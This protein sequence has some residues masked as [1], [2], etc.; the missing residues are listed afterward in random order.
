MN[1][2]RKMW[3]LEGL[4]RKEEHTSKGE[5]QRL[6]DLSLTDGKMHQRQKNKKARTNQWMLEVFSGFEIIPCIKS[7]NRRILFTK[8][9]ERGEVNTS[10]KGIANVFGEFHSKLYDD[11]Q[12]DNTETEYDKNETENNIEDRG[13]D[14]KEM[15]E[16]LEITTEELQTQ[17]GKI[18]RQQWNQSRRHQSVRRRNERD[19]ETDLQWNNKTQRIYTRSMAKNQNKSKTQN[20]WRWR[21]WKLSPD[22]LFACAVQTVYDNT[23]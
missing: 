5:K 2:Q 6:K 18:S 10:R 3:R 12:Y 7:A 4:S 20:R 17:K 15:K 8:K 11:D 13:T 19:G 16:I 9:N 1:S 23:V 22:L 21:W 14:T